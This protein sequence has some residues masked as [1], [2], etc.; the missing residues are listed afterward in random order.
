MSS[1]G[2]LIENRVAREASPVSVILLVGTDHSGSRALLRLSQSAWLS[3]GGPRRCLARYWAIR[4]E[5]ASAVV[6]SHCLL[7]LGE[8]RVLAVE[9]LHV[10]L[11]TPRIAGM[12]GQ[13]GRRSWRGYSLIILRMGSIVG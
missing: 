9:V 13:E 8:E 4:K 6:W 2:I 7:V 5:A 10:H 11:T 3:K 1:L 12:R